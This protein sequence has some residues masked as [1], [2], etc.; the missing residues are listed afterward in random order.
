ML[1]YNLL[2]QPMT[3]RRS[4]KSLQSDDE[5]HIEKLDARL[6]FKKIVAALSLFP[7]KT[8]LYEILQ[9]QAYQDIYGPAKDAE[10]LES[11]LM[12]SRKT[13]LVQA[14]IEMMDRSGISMAFNNT[15]LLDH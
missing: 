12:K 15:Y 6:G 14:Y 3:I 2:F 8:N 13:G 5:K 9:E 7:S 4:A 11:S 1:R 10:E